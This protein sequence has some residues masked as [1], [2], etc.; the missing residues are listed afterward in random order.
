MGVIAPIRL[1]GFNTI[2]QYLR[3][4]GLS[5]EQAPHQVSQIQ[6]TE[7]VQ[8]SWP[9]QKQRAVVLSDWSPS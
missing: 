3:T 8:L 5:K 2:P 7:N 1:M 6:G 9:K 4:I